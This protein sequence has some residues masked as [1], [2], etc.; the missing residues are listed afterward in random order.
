MLSLGGGSNF[1]PQ[2]SDVSQHSGDSE[3]RRKFDST[4]TPHINKTRLQQ[5]TS[6]G[7][8]P[9]KVFS[10]R[11]FKPS[12]NDEPL[13][14]RQRLVQHDSKRVCAAPGAA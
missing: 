10:A 9:A 7:A 5:S 12:P 6:G 14:Q 2:K 13:L 4:K 3:K 8:A 11:G 1:V